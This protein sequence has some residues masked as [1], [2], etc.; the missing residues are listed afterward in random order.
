[1]AVEEIR[2]Y[3]VQI[4][5][6]NT[7]KEL[8]KEISDLRDKLVKLDSTSEDYKK[9]VTDL[10][11][12][13]TK[14]KEVM[15][16]GKTQ[17]KAAEGSYNAL[18]NQ[19]A[20]L[21]KVWREVTDQAS[22]DEIGAQIKDINDQLK[23]MDYSL[24][25]FQRNV[26]N[27]EG[28]L[29]NVFLT[30]QQELKKLRTELA[31]LEVGT[32]AYEKTFRRMA[33]LTHD[34][35]EQQEQLKWSSSDLG[36]MLGNLV[37]VAQ[38]VAGAFSVVN[39]AMG[40]MG[41]ESEDVQ[42]AML[43]VQQLMAIVQGLGALEEL[44][45]RVKGLSKGFVEFAG[46]LFKS[47]TSVN[48]FNSEATAGA[49]AA[50]DMAG[51][52]NQNASAANNA[53][54]AVDR[55]TVSIEQLRVA[56]EEATGVEKQLL[57]AMMDVDIQNYAESL[58]DAADATI[59]F[60]GETGKLYA[61]MSGETF[62]VEN[63]TEAETQLMAKNTGLLKSNLQ[64]K[65]SLSQ[66]NKWQI[67]TRASTKAQIK[68]NE[69]LILSNNLQA[70]SWKVAGAAC[71]AF[72]VALASTGIGLI[73]VALGELL[74]LLGKGISSLWKWVDGTKKAAEQADNLRRANEEL[75]AS[76]DR[77]NEAMDR[78]ERMMEAQGKSYDEI[79]Q[80][81]KKN[82]EAQLAEVEGELKIQE[83]IANSIGAKKLQKKKYEEF[84]EELENLR[85][86]AK[87]LRKDI[88]NLNFDKE[89]HDVAEATKAAQ[90]L[91]ST[92][93][94]VT[95]TIV[96]SRNKEREEAE[97]LLKSLEESFKTE[98]QKLDEKYK[99][100]KALLEKYGKDTT[101]LTRKYEADKRKIVEDEMKKRQ[102]AYKSYNAQIRASMGDEEGL[103]SDVSDAEDKVATVQT[104]EKMGA[105]T[106][107][108]LTSEM[109]ELFKY[110]G[111]TEEQF[112]AYAKSARKELSDA[113]QALFDFYDTKKMAEYS[114]SMEGL[115]KQTES[116]AKG[117]SLFYEKIAAA[118]WNGQLYP[119]EVQ[120]QTDREYEIMKE[121]LTKQLALYQQM[122]TDL[123]LSKDERLDAQSKVTETMMAMDDLE[124]Q[125]EIDNLNNKM[126]KWQEYTD[127]TQQVAN[128]IGSI[129]GNVSDAMEQ[130]IQNRIASG[131]ITQEEGEK[132]FESVK[133]IQIAEAYM[134]AFG[135]AVGAYQSMASIPY[136]GP[137]LG[138]VAAAA[139]LAAG[140]AQA[141]SIKN[142]TLNGS[143]TSSSSSNRYSEV[144]PSITS[145]YDPTYTQN[146]TG[147][148]ETEQLA[149]ALSSTPIKA[150][151][152][153]SEMTS[154]QTK[155]QNRKNETTF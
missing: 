123:Q 136:V 140:I 145:D 117:V 80:A 86:T 55:T 37:G 6:V 2:T 125:H 14:L 36:D 105:G 112:E 127:T 20:A 137:A 107:A 151:V 57:G 153:E 122:S 1:M 40:L 65:D 109:Q 129:L 85:N 47:S 18:V 90:Q 71:K 131:K 48:E 138:A 25:N 49:G 135:A 149:N 51:G 32:E 70:V 63:L 120:Q 50:N 73:V 114:A 79:Y 78:T 147:E 132:E 143:S 60:E 142:T 128:G 83:A 102:E 12:D 28:A 100:E 16:A 134:N 5:G 97:K 45:D 69:A 155:A 118:R 96:E 87:G 103:K 81:K 111:I 94:S 76:I 15:T 88:D 30:P 35:T 119:E 110:L 29:R 22:R 98:V 82:L 46:N 8:K 52:L 77:Q 74:S 93:T 58:S 115:T 34:V 126:N 33:Q 17:A 62:E 99:E 150:Y 56:Y 130:N 113:K 67:L 104:L 39:A 154:A 61:A 53:T 59:T 4:E 26:G 23:Q 72:K 68:E 101:L 7:V 66:T 75:T 21:K 19:M 54:Q 41:S 42:K 106:N 10:V 92:T 139:A 124:T 44:G 3:E 91:S 43:K 121:G 144:T 11:K 116:N 64:L 95:N 108:P 141:Q 89:V 146:L 24:G 27:Y 9:V 31:G 148:Q 84:R 152:V 38:G 13:E 133:K